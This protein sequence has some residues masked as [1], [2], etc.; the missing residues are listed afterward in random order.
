MEPVYFAKQLLGGPEFKSLARLQEKEGKTWL[1][2]N[3]EC[4]RLVPGLQREIGTDAFQ[5]APLPIG[6]FK[7]V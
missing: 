6:K 4:Q 5:K 2:G 3:P 1:A 7:I